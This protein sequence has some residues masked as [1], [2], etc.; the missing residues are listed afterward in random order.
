MKEIFETEER[1]DCL[2][3]VQKR[4]RKRESPRERKNG[5]DRTGKRKTEKEIDERQE[6]KR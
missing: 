1:R 5:K 4:E 6:R 2:G 3:I